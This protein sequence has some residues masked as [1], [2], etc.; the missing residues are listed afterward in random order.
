MSRA[1]VDVLLGQSYFL[2]FDPKL[3]AAQQPYPPLGTLYA[4][5]HLRAR[6]HHVGLFDAMLAESEAEWDQALAQTRPKIAVLYED[7]FNY[8][9][10]MC[11]L[12]MREAAFAMARMARNRGCTV[13]VAGSDATDHAQAYL[14]AGADYVLIGEGEE[15]LGDLFD[16][17]LHNADTPLEDILGLAYARDGQL[18]VNPRRPDLK[19]LDALPFPAWD[20]VDIDRYRAIWRTHHGYYSMNVATSRGCPYHCNWCAKPIWGQRY[21]VRS[22]A[23]VADEIAWLKRTFNPDHI[24]F[25]DDIFGLIPG[26]VE[27]FA[28]E[29][30]ARDARLP[31]KSLQRADLIL[32]GNTI[33]ALRRAGAHRV[34]VGAESGSQKILDAM[35]KGT[36]VEDIYATAQRLHEAGIEVGFFLQ[37]GYPGETRD[38]IERTLQMVRECHPNDIGMSV[39]YPLP[40]TRFFTAVQHELGSKQNWQDSEDLAMLYNGPFSTSFYRWLHRVLHREFRAQR[41]SDELHTRHPSLRRRLRLYAAIVRS[42]ATLPILRLELE[43]RARAPHKG[44][45]NLIPVEAATE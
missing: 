30:E 5:S 10:K 39:S 25:V 9:S 34:W 33:D 44:L 37:F 40:G 22:A 36:R 16:V 6:G 8:L 26:W 24:W 7:N 27:E 3:W 17:L 28:D 35:D 13:V 12:R 11:L 20:L 31:F 41:A 1:S 14:D 32:K 23:N 38:D 4:A 29:I 42:K 18:Q 21:H 19:D 43:R 2:R 15:T 45:V